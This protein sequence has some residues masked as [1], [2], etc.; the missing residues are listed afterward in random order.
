MPCI[1]SHAVTRY[2]RE[3]QAWAAKGKRRYHNPYALGI[4]LQ[5]VEECNGMIQQ[6]MA[7]EEALR[8]CFERELLAYI[9]KFIAEKGN[10]Y[11]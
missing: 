10:Q 1:L 5:R 2:D 7:R 9:L 8:E 4:Y 3:N 6:G 11:A